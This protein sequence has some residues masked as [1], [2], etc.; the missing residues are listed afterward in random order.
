[1]PKKDKKDTDIVVLGKT[2]SFTGILKFETTLRI[3][4][5]FRGT[6]EAAGALIVDKEAVVDADHITVSSLTVYGSI[7]GTVHA[8]DKVDMMSGARVHG[9]V[10]AARLRIADGVLFEGK[11]KMTNVEKDVEIFHRPTEEIKADLQRSNARA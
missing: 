6:I 9:D 7:S 10:S 3:Q 4:G 5:N 8:L 2:T 11:C 1:M